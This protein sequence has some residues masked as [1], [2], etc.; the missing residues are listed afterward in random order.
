MR[1]DHAVLAAT[2]VVAKV[3]FTLHKT[4]PVSIVHV[5]N[6][7]FQITRYGW[8]PFNLGVR[9]D[10]K[11]SLQVPPLTASHAL[12]FTPVGTASNLIVGTFFS[13]QFD[14]FFSPSVGDVD[15]NFW[16]FC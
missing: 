14:T 5:Y 12:A 8:G 9:I 6:F 3:T 2:D 10:L 11:P 13:K 15:S 1:L 16:F 4:F 7:P